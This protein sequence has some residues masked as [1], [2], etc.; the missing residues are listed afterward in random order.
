[1]ISEVMKILGH[2][3]RPNIEAMRG[4]AWKNA[5]A[6]QLISPDTVI[7]GVNMAIPGSVLEYDARLESLMIYREAQGAAQV[8]H[9][10]DMLNR[11]ALQIARYVA[12][13]ASLPALT[14][15]GLSGGLDSRIC[16]AAA[17]VVGALPELR[18]GSLEARRRDFE[19]ASALAAKAGFEL[20]RPMG[21]ILGDYERLQSFNTW[22]LSCLGIYDPLYSPRNYRARGLSFAISGHGAELYKGNYGWRPLSKLD[23]YR[24]NIAFRNQSA[25]AVRALGVE[26]EHPWATEWH[27][28]GY[29]NA[30]HS[31]RFTMSSVL[32]ARPIANRD[33]LRLAYSG[34]NIWPAPA[35]G[36]PSIVNDILI[37]LS[38]S[39]AAVPFD[40]PAKDM[41]QE[42]I[43][44]RRAALDVSLDTPAPYKLVGKLTDNPGPIPAFVE[45]ARKRGFA[46]NIQPKRC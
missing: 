12:T 30:I 44:A 19:I 40:D 18:I 21:D 41:S 5:M 33:L 6:A 31:G 35:K 45:R 11:G 8:G 7:D 1:M 2:D 16:L 32:G 24:N 14:T 43:S 3:P 22:A 15:L 10:A 39:L 34:S 9:Y 20:N 46:G 37:A 25:E 17:Q 23:G 26:P 42:F 27:Y 13:L 29:R 28:F 38:P 4:R 36:A